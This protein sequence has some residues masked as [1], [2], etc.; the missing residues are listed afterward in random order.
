[1]SAAKA[2]CSPS[3]LGGGGGCRA[4]Q[5][6]RTR[7]RRR[8]RSPPPANRADVERVPVEARQSIIDHYRGTITANEEVPRVNVA[9]NHTLSVQVRV[10]VE[11]RAT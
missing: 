8:N 1:M 9:V 6:W 3:A 4:R 5:A 11:N 10:G 2:Y 7:A